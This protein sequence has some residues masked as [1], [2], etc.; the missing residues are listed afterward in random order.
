M[1]G[2]WQLDDGRERLLLLLVLAP[3]LLAGLAFLALLLALLLPPFA[4]LLAFAFTPGR[5]ALL[6]RAAQF[7]SVLALLLLP[8]PNDGFDHPFERGLVDTIFLGV[9][10][11][12][13]VKHP[14]DG[15]QPAQPLN[16]DPQA[17]GL[18][19]G[20]GEFDDLRRAVLGRIISHVRRALI[21]IW[22]R[23]AKFAIAFG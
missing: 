9:P 5:V 10:L 12:L 11:A 14:F 1:L 19:F 17:A 23:L 18:L 2:L 13:D 8:L 6:L 22:S 4:F 7:T 3:L 20:V 15:R 16:L 21:A